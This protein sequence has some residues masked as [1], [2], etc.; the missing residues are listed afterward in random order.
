MIIIIRIL[1]KKNKIF[2]HRLKTDTKVLI[3]LKPVPISRFLKFIKR[4]EET[5]KRKRAT[6]NFKLTIQSAPIL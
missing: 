2:I 6:G 4:L 3:R 1:L 5:D